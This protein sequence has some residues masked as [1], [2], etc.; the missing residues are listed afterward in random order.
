MRRHQQN[1]ATVADGDALRDEA[2]SYD[3]ERGAEC[4]PENAANNNTKRILASSEDDG[5]DLRSITPL[6]KECKHKRLNKHRR[7]HEATP[8]AT[9]ASVW[10]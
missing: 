7:E 1:K 10:R 5:R 6:R 4:M 3:G 8:L 9:L 2:T